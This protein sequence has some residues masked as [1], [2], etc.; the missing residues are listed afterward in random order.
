MREIKFRA[1]NEK[2]GEWLD[3]AEHVIYADDG[4]VAEV[5]DLE[6]VEFVVKNVKLEQFTGLH[7]KNGKEIYEG[8]IVKCVARGSN[9]VFIMEVAYSNDWAMFYIHSNNH[10]P[11]GLSVAFYGLKVIGNVHENPELIES[12]RKEN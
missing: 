4:S 11:R 1:W 3:P 10:K 7:D 5:C 12:N 2:Y 9:D 8:D 6:L